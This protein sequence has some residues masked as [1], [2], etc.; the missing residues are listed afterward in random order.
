MQVYGR[1]RAVGIEFH[2]TWFAGSFIYPEA[3]EVYTPNTNQIANIEDTL[4]LAHS[5]AFILD[6][7]VCRESRPSNCV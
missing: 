3:K 7:T 6:G 2:K 5:G 1:F 4:V